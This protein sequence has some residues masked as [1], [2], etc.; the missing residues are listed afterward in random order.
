MPEVGQDGPHKKEWEAQQKKEN[1]ND[2]FNVVIVKV[3]DALL[4]FV[5]SYIASWVLNSGASF[6]TTT[7]HEILENYVDGNHGNV[8]LVDQNVW[9]LLVWM[10]LG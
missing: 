3:Q 5:D 6:H 10:M 2:T 8:Y 9:I 1:S 4:L 7:H